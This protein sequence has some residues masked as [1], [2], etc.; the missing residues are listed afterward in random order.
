V[1]YWNGK[2][3][4]R[5]APSLHPLSTGW[6]CIDCG[7]CNGIQWG[8][9]YPTECRD[10]GGGGVVFL[11]EASGLV[12]AW[13]GGPIVGGRWPQSEV[14]RQLDLSQFPARLVRGKDGD[15]G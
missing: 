14:I 15:D 10:C 8:G 11:H 13:P 6:W 4:V 9:E 5:I 1:S 12:A 2:E 7:C 3:I